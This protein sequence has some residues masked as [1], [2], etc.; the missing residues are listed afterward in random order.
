VLVPGD[1]HEDARGP[2]PVPHASSTSFSSV[3]S[4]SRAFRRRSK[5]HRLSGAA[6]GPL[7]L[8]ERS[9]GRGME[10]TSP[11]PHCTNC[12][13]IR[14]R[15]RN[16]PHRRG[17]DGRPEKG[18]VERPGGSDSLRRALPRLAHRPGVRALPGPGSTRHRR[19]KS[20][21]STLTEGRTSRGSNEPRFPC[22]LPRL[23]PGIGSR[24]RQAG[25]LRSDVS[26]SRSL[27]RARPAIDCQARP[28]LIER[29]E[30][31]GKLCHRDVRRATCV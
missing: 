29:K 16:R 24:L 17:R 3:R 27:Q 7:R 8:F 30:R 22:R 25:V 4:S 6:T 18:R 1:R 31:G 19:H 26:R 14:H 2:P 5:E 23:H 9:G 12:P 15:R 20:W 13:E 10:G 11:R 21:S 28:C